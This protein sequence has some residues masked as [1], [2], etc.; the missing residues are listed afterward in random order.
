MS[1]GNNTGTAEAAKAAGVA[2][3]GAAAGAATYGVMGGIGVA[4]GGTAV[5]ITLAPFIAI[6]AGI[7][8]FGYGL[9]WLGRQSSGGSKR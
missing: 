2:G 7:G 9:Y 5:G 3:I 8:L 1:Q 6:G 4:A